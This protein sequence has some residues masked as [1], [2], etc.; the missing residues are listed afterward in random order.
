MWTQ[1]GVEENVAEAYRRDITD[2]ALN[3][4]AT[5]QIFFQGRWYNACFTGY[6]TSGAYCNF[7]CQS[8]D[9]YGHR[10]RTGK[11]HDTEWIYSVRI[12]SEYDLT[13]RWLSNLGKASEEKKKSGQA[14]GSSKG[15]EGDKEK[16]KSGEDGGSSKCTMPTTARGG[17]TNGNEE[18]MKRGK[19][20][21]PLKRPMP[22]AARGR[23]AKAHKP[24]LAGHDPLPAPRT[25][26]RTE[27]PHLIALTQEVSDFLV[28]SVRDHFGSEAGSHCGYESAAVQAGMT[29]EEMHTYIKVWRCRRARL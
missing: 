18:K 17:G 14:G 21:G 23:P 16:I 4:S 20:G 10:D 25:L 6:T 11:S 29:V 3:F 22:P 1:K 2:R 12:G 28:R 24:N 9:I 27:S 13:V 8:C 5:H 19:S 26:G 15:M 7:N